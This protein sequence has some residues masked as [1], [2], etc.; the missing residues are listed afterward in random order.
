MT[1]RICR[2]GT[3]VVAIR[4]PVEP[5]AGI[6]DVLSHPAFADHLQ[7]GDTVFIRA[8]IVVQ[9]LQAELPPQLPN[10]VLV[11]GSGRR[12][13]VNRNIRLADSAQN[14]QPFRG[15]Q[16]EAVSDGHQQT[17]CPHGIVSQFPHP[18]GVVCALVGEIEVVGA[19]SQSERL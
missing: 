7:G 9:V 10:H 19:A 1:P 6:G 16:P 4:V 17:T 18:P 15:C 8:K 12:Q 3:V 14:R 11:S 13:L 2:S 5:F